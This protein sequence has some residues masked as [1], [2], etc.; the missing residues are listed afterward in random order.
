M[1]GRAWHEQDGETVPLAIGERR[2]CWAGCAAGFGEPE[3]TW[4]PI[5]GIRRVCLL[6]RRQEVWQVQVDSVN[7]GLIWI[8][9]DV[10]DITLNG[11]YA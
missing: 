6:A 9:V 2:L 5:Y 10:F 8:N 3:Y 4:Q 11:A 7:L 1:N